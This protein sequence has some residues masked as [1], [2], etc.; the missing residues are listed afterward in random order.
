MKDK[1]LA[2]EAHILKWD[3]SG[4]C[5]GLKTLTMSTLFCVLLIL[6]SL[7]ERKSH[8]GPFNPFHLLNKSHNIVSLML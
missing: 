6:S 5:L 4:K 7:F 8:D 2:T 1:G 3:K